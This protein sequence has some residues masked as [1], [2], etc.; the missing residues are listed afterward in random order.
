[1]CV[2]RSPS[3]RWAERLQSPPLLLT[4]SPCLTSAE[5]PLPWTQQRVKMLLS[6]PPRTGINAYNGYT[7]KNSKK[8]NNHIHS[9]H[10]PLP[11]SLL[12]SPLAETK[13]FCRLD[14]LLFE[15]CLSMNERRG[16]LSCSVLES[17]SLATFKLSSCFD[18]SQ[19]FPALDLNC[20]QLELDPN[21]PNPWMI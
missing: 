20:W 10:P 18:L 7:G 15:L 16:C 21:Q 5:S 6:A 9:T 8:V 13:P 12:L 4:L 3:E 1:M 17:D 14:A 11:S 2:E 19:P